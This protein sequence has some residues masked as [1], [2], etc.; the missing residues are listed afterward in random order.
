VLAAVLVGAGLALVASTVGV[1]LAAESI[2]AANVG[3]RTL[4]PASATA[5]ELLAVVIDQE[6]GERG[7]VITEEPKFLQPY[8]TGDVEA[9]ELVATLKRELAGHSDALGLLAQ[10]DDRYQ[11]WLKD[12]A[13]AQIQDVSSGHEAKAVATE[14]SG[15]GKA[16]FDYVRDSMSSLNSELDREQQGE[17]S[18]VHGLQVSLLWLTVAVGACL[19]AGAGVILLLLRRW[20]IDPVQALER[21]VALVARGDVDRKVSAV[22]PVEIQDLGRGVEVMRARV[23]EASNEARVLRGVAETLQRS[24]APV[25]APHLEGL[26]VAVRYLPGTEGVEIGGDWFNFLDIG[27]GRCFFAIG[28]VS[29]RGLDA[30]TQMAEFRY[31]INAYAKEN[32][33]PDEVLRRLGI[34]CPMT[35]QGYFATVLC[36]ICD[37]AAHTV[38]LSSAGHPAPLIVV[39]G[40][41]RLAEVEP[42]PPICLDF[43]N[44]RATNLKVDEGSTILSF[45][46]GLVERRGETLT[47]GLERLCRAASVDM[48]LEDM[49]DH[50]V[51]TMIPG[52]LSDDVAIVAV[53]WG[54]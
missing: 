14:K 23:R 8:S 53:R 35:E 31:A 32:P 45:T 47:D 16:L 4:V 12:Y 48:G 51:A 17:I 54:M 43:H 39:K 29:G 19:L 40:R 42:G 1:V 38:A 28:D 21:E 41:A 22:G 5:N 26:S 2:D 11:D 37:P 27:D 15:R 25:A 36:G 13:Q 3:L 33:M 52:D 6:T 49:L 20:V 50:V 30:A 34:L 9:P 7:Y 10:F 44:Y 18:R 46:D 24:L